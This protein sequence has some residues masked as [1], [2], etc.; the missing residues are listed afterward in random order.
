MDITVV[1]CPGYR[2]TQGL[3]VGSGGKSRKKTKSRGLGEGGGNFGSEEVW[4]G[5]RSAIRR[6]AVRAEPYV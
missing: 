5:E 4:L 1:V 3:V 6:C 2:V